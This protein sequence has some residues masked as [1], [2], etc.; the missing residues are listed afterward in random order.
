MEAIKFMYFANNFSQEQLKGCF[1]VTNAPEHL[2]SKFNAL[3]DKHQQN[4][5]K[6]FLDWFMLLSRD[7]Q[8]QVVDYINA[9][10]KG[11]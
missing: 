3:S 4:G 11:I 10:Y 6:M 5:T 2:K 7:N 8:V 9:N 1:N